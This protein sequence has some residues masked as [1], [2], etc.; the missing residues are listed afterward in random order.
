MFLKEPLVVLNVIPLCTPERGYGL[1]HKYRKLL[2][3]ELESLIAPKANA[4]E[5]GNI[6]TNL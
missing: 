3:L 5:A 4:A 6:I 1:K 2:E